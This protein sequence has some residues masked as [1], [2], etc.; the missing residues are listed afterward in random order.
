MFSASPS[1][2]KPPAATLLV[3]GVGARRV[4]FREWAVTL[5]EQPQCRQGS[6]RPLSAEKTDGEPTCGCAGGRSRR[7]DTTAVMRF[8]QPRLLDNQ[9]ETPRWLGPTLSGLEL[10]RSDKG[11]FVSP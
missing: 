1:V 9:P 11:P 2:P 5:Q 4:I 3:S 6:R 8:L 10:G 7:R